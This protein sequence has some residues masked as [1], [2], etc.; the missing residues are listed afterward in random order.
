MA[1]A[2]VAPPIGCG[3]GT[4]T[5]GFTTTGA[6]GAGG[7]TTN[8]AGGFKGGGAVTGGPRRDAVEWRPDS[9]T[10]VSPGFPTNK[11]TKLAVNGWYQSTSPALPTEA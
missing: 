7:A 9:S 10:T 8:E 3:T 5:G 4:T 2:V 6:A 11:A 1:V